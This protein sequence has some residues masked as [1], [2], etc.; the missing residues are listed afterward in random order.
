MKR[1][2]F[3]STTGAMAIATIVTSA[4]SAT[5]QTPSG[6]TI[7]SLGHTCFL[8]TGGG[9]QILVNPFRPLGCTAQYPAPNVEADLV[10]IS[11][12][13]LDEGYVEDL[14]GQPRLLFEPGDYQLNGGLQVRGMV[15]ERLEK[16]PGSRFPSNV[17]WVWKQAGIKLLHLGGMASPIT[18]EQKILI[19]RP[20]VVFIPVGGGPKAYSPE[21]AQA[22]LEILN[23]KIV[24][25][26]HY[27]TQQADP[28]VCDL[29]RVDEFLALM[30]GTAVQRIAGDRLTLQAN[31]LPNEG[32]QI[33]VLS[34]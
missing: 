3:I 1:R 2:N 7:Q 28:Q 14:P 22:A 4:Y 18:V 31:G 15:A 8:F 9:H 10:L 16:Q 12:Q 26:T 6:L 23:A 33:K 13:L 27:Q 5:A 32:S 20:D 17:S 34:L 21:E 25:P 29:A 30:N 24:I 19:G 11:S